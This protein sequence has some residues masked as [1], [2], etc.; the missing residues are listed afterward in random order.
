MA[1]YT[2]KDPEIKFFTFNDLPFD[3]ENL[4]LKLN[5]LNNLPEDIQ[6]D[7]DRWGPDDSVVRDDIFLFLLDNQFNLTPSQYYESEICKNRFELN[8]GPYPFDLDKLKSNG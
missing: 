4:D 7:I 3:N 5:I 6:K 2:I 1:R 8:L